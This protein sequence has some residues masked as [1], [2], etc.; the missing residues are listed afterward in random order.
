MLDTLTRPRDA[1]A[2]TAEDVLAG[3]DLTGRRVLMT[4]V[5]SRLGVEAARALAVR[6]AHVVGAARDL[7]TAGRA[8]EVVWAEARKGGGVSLVQLDLAD[9]RNVRACADQLLEDGL[10]FD[11]VIA[12]AGVAATRFALTQD[13][14]ET[15]FGTNH[16]GHFVLINRVEPLIKDG[17]RVVMLSSAGH[18]FANVDADDPNFDDAEYEPLVA[19]G[20]SKTANI[21]F[22]VEFDRRHKHRGVRA[23][24]VGSDVIPRGAAT[25]AWAAAVADA[26]QIGGRY[27][28]DC[29]VAPVAHDDAPSRF[30]VRAY[31]VDPLRAATLWAL[32]EAMVGER[33]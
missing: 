13:G 4:G 26:D 23:A 22:A 6:G 5:S 16:L 14:F 7:E 31:A 17:G 27:C 1:A 30:G 29:G 2:S 9:L 25:V 28:E 3:V 8:T 11:L 12:G 20:R 32:S 15:H 10:G 21:L 18:R 33:F 24:A 19:Y